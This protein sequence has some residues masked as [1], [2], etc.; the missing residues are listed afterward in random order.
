[1]PQHIEEITPH[2]LLEFFSEWEV[3]VKTRYNV[4]S[5]VKDVFKFAVLADY[6]ER[7]PARVVPL[8]KLPPARDPGYL[9]FAECERL[10]TLAEQT[11]KTVYFAK[12]NKAIVMFLIDA[13]VRNLE[14][15][16]L[17]KADVQRDRCRVI[18]KGNKEREPVFGERTYRALC[19]HWELQSKGVYCFENPG[20]S[21]LN[22]GNVR[23][24]CQRLSTHLGRRIWPHLLRHTCASLMLDKGANMRDVQEQLGHASISTTQRYTHV[25]A[26]GRSRRHQRHSPLA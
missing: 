11:A 25:S 6:L 2:D 19:A 13:G 24:L 17:L 18:G 22:T 9:S 4:V 5:L 3:A 20:G 8:P 7:S 23:R 1:M 15:C 16:T 26:D 14:L 12:R 10:I 21:R